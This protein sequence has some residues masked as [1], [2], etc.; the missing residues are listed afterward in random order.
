VDSA[1]G[2]PE[3]VGA[4]HEAGWM[5]DLGSGRMSPSVLI[6][7]RLLPPDSLNTGLHAPEQPYIVT[8]T[9]P[10]GILRKATITP[11]P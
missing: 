1:A 4:Y 9:Q 8:I 10:S 2:L 7:P 11:V 5:E 6:V 3:V